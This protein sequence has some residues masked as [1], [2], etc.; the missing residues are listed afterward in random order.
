M[1]GYLCCTI[2][3]L[4]VKPRVDPWKGVLKTKKC[5]YIKTYNIVGYGL[6]I[7]HKSKLTRRKPLFGHI[8]DS[9]QRALVWASELCDRLEKSSPPRGIYHAPRSSSRP[10]PSRP[11]LVM[12]PPTVGALE[13]VMIDD[14]R[15]DVLR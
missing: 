8:M 7:L 1:V 4:W 14:G 9:H 11:T 15:F 6:T 13:M 12:A 3:Y 5:V 2:G 10:P